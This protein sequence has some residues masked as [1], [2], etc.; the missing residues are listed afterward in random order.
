[1]AALNSTFIVDVSQVLTGIVKTIT[2]IPNVSGPGGPTNP[3][4]IEL[5]HQADVSPDGKILIVNDE[6]GGGL[7]NTECNTDP[8]GVIGA[9]HFWALGADPGRAQVDGRQPGDAEEA[10]DLHQPDPDAPARSAAAGDRPAASRRARLHVARLPDRRERLGL[11]GPIASGFDGVS[12]LGPRELVEAWYGAGVWNINFSG[13]SRSND[14]HAEDPRSTW[15]NTLGWNVMPGADTW[16]AKEY[17]GNIYA[18]DM[19]RGF[20]VYTFAR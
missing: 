2:V 15:G 12:R 18:G 8:N 3:D 13:P 17:K 20:D 11:P 9:L 5:S 16:S 6:R 14:R 4:N 19:L 1:M 10:R 7:D